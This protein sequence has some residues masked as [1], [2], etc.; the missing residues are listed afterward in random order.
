MASDKVKIGIMYSLSGPGEVVGKLQQEGAKLAIKDVNDAGGVSISGKTSLVEGFFFDDETKPEV[1]TKH[2]KAMAG[3]GITA[4]VGGTFG[5]VSLA[6]N[7]ACKKTKMFFI[8]TNAPPDDFFKVGVKAPAS[9]SII[10]GGADA[11]RSAA[12]YIADQIKPKKVACFIPSYPLG[13]AV[14]D[15]FKDIMNQ[16]PE[17]DCKVFWHPVGSKDMKRDLEAV[18]QYKPDMLFVSSWGSDAIS[19]L[20]EAHNIGLKKDCKV[21]HFWMLNSFAMN[22]PPEA[23]EGVL[24]QVFWYHDLSGFTDERVVQVTAEFTSRYFKAYG[25]PPD[26]YAMAAYYGVREAVRAIE[27]AGSVDPAKVYAAL[28]ASPNWHGAK[29]EAVWR[30]DGRANLSV[31]LLDC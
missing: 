12:S 11:G 27:K 31:F 23:F 1:A 3:Q 5:H 2:F 15:G 22:I 25:S 18:R 8:A 7:D 16:H 19:A 30:K 21:F 9:A 14:L 4:L 26:A 17:I 29:G 10:G 24:S 6:L 20:K 13:K 28:M